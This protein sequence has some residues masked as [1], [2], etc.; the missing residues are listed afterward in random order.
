M[1]IYFGYYGKRHSRYEQEVLRRLG[2][3]SSSDPASADIILLVQTSSPKVTGAP[4]LVTGIQGRYKQMLTNKATFY[5]HFAHGRFF[6]PTRTFRHSL[7]D[8]EP[9]KL[10]ILKP[11]D[12]YMGRGN[13]V[14]E[15]RTVA[16]R[17]LKHHKDIAKW[18]LQEYVHTALLDGHKFH[19]RIWVVVTVGSKGSALWISNRGRYDV[20]EK[21]YVEGRYNEMDIHDTHEAGDLFMP[22]V[23]PDT[24]TQKET[25]DAFDA[26]IDMVTELARPLTDC[27]PDWTAQNGFEIFAADVIFDKQSHRPFVLEVNRKVGFQEKSLPIY[28]AALHCV[29]RHVFRKGMLH[30]GEARFFTKLI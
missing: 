24:W 25:R 6:P 1:K 22:S 29:T 12:S 11:E 7:P 21:P 5:E 2:A 30:Q 23:K 4:K 13:I 18:C 28:L 3:S 20:A 14:F 9:G 17:H 8:T 15:D 16:S 10:Y 19:V 27:K 26:A